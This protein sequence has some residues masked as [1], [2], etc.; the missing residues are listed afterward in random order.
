VTAAS[1]LRRDW[2][3]TP[4]SERKKGSS[5]YGSPQEFLKKTA[6]HQQSRGQCKYRDQSVRP[7][8]GFKPAITQLSCA[9]SRSKLFPTPHQLTGDLILQVFDR[10]HDISPCRVGFPINSCIKSAGASS[11]RRLKLTICPLFDPIENAAQ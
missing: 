10:C 8:A 11:S 9:Q 2:S 5:R 4:L 7:L 6:Q 1:T 3:G